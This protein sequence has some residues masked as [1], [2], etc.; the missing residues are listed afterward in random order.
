MQS[1][2]DSIWDI[3][4]TQEILAL[5]S[6]IGIIVVTV[7][8]IVVLTII[9]FPTSYPDPLSSFPSQGAMAMLLALLL[10]AYAL[11]TAFPASLFWHFPDPQISALEELFA[12]RL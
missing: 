4:S 5:V 9:Y 6:I 1:V 11:V 7:T 12:T 10:P 3:I 2:L 8:V